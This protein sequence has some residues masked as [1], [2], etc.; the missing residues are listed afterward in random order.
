MCSHLILKRLTRFLEVLTHFLPLYFKC[1]VVSPSEL[2]RKPSN[3]IWGMRVSHGS[4]HDV[5]SH[6]GD[7]IYKIVFEKLP[8][9]CR[10]QESNPDLTHEKQAH[11]FYHDS[12]KN[13][14]ATLR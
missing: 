10:H 12:C 2:I 5:S 13:N 3:Q 1:D 8:A 9:T 6:L 11:C 7:V 14:K 4:P